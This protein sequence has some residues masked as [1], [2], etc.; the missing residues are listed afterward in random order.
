MIG[1][2]LAA[3]QVAPEPDVWTDGSRVDDRLSTV[4][5]SGAGFSTGH[6]SCFWAGCSWGQ[7]DDG[8]QGN[9]GV[10]CCRGYCSVPGPLQ[11]VQRAEL[12]GVILALQASRG[13]HLGVDNL[14]VVRHVGR[15]LDGDIG[16]LPFLVV[17]DGD[18]LCLIHHM[19]LL[20]GPDT[21]RVTKVKG[22]ASEDMV[23]GG[24]V[25]DVDRLGNNA[26]DE[27]AD[28][29]RRRV[30]VRVV[31]ARR[32][33]VGVCSR[34][35]PVVSH[36]HRFFVAI[37]RAV[38]NHDDG[39]GTAPNPLVWSAGSLPKKRRVVD[40]VRNFAFLPGPVDIWSGDWAASAVSRITVDDVRVWPYSVSL[41]VKMSVFLSI[42]HWP[43]GDADLGVGGVSFVELLI[44][45]ELWAGE[46]LCLERAVPK[47]RRVGRPISV[48]AVHF[49]PGIDIWRSCRFLGAIFRALCFLPGGLRRFIPGNL[50]ANHG[51]LRHNGWE[52]CCHG[53]T[54]RPRETSSVRFLDEL[55]FLFGYPVAS[56][57][58]LLAG[59][60]PLRYFSENFA[61]KVP[62]WR[63]PGDGS[64]ACFLASRG[65]VRGGSCA[66]SAAL[67]SAGFCL[68]SGSGGGLKE[69]DYTEKHLHTLLDR[70]FLGSR[71]VPRFGRDFGIL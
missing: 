42:L 26:A 61:R 66:L 13:V 48:S 1:G 32:N 15:L 65:L 63:L 52:K 62:T 4:S 41:L 70:V 18:L 27:A 49:C 38:V 50:G 21:V 11:S 60:L 9:Q 33:L 5:S 53:L 59:T 55:L 30:P 24:R 35:Y 17:P 40:A 8:D 29:G 58:S 46:R 31:D 14:N 45:F 68:N 22:H 28:F 71:I 67:G 23:V 6:P 57:S 20:R 54:S 16:A 64:V 10:A 47:F 34:W 7:V 56:G 43:A 39:S 37:A 51:R 36:L 19:L 2:Y 44:L 25:R 12:W 3:L 69:S